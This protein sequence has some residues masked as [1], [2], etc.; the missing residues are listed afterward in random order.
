[1]NKRINLFVNNHL[2]IIIPV[3]V[4]ILSFSKTCF[5]QDD[6]IRGV[7]VSWFYDV[8]FSQLHDSLNLNWAQSQVEVGSTKIPSVL[9]NGYLKLM[10]VATQMFWK[11]KA[12]R[13]VFEAEANGSDPLENYFA[14]TPSGRPDPNVDTLL[15]SFGS[16]GYMVK[17]AVPDN[18]Y[19]YK[20]THYTASFILKCAPASGDPQIVRLE[21]ICKE[22]GTTLNYKI[23]KY[24]DFAPN[25]WETKTLEIPLEYEPNPSLKQP[26]MLL[27]ES[28]DITSTCTGVDIRVW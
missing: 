20:I 7:Y 11:P 15:V 25:N 19:N 22:D 13:M 1:M 17:S 6:F 24:S 21:A 26:G 4:L 2:R 18:Q 12:Q 28:Q 8:D 14:E 10:G 9:N 27:G 3:V 5:A 23:L 16:P